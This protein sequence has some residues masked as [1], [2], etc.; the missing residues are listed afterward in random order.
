MF[1]EFHVSEHI[2]SLRVTYTNLVRD[3][4]VVQLLFPVTNIQHLPI[5][6]C[7]R[8]QNKAIIIPIQQHVIDIQECFTAKHF[9]IM[10]R[11]QKNNF[12]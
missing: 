9:H 6:V 8:R 5:L 12:R 3:T 1:L 10:E 2:S 4:S 11:I 7:C